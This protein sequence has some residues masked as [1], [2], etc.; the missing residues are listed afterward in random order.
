MNSLLKRAVVFSITTTFVFN[1]GLGQILSYADTSEIYK[2]A[3]D[4][5]SSF[6][7]KNIAQANYSVATT[8]EVSTNSDSSTFGDFTY[9]EENGSVTITEY[10]GSDASIVIPSKINNMNVTAIGPH[11]F[12][13]KGLK[14]VTIPNSVTSIGNYAFARCVLLEE[15]IIPNSVTSIGNAA[16][17]GCNHLKKVTIP[18]SVTSIGDS[19]FFNCQLL[20]T[21]VIPSSVTSIGDSAFSSI[22][23]DATI[24]GYPDSYAEEYATQYNIQ[25]KSIFL[26]FQ[27]SN[28][29]IDTNS[30]GDICLEFNSSN[31]NPE[32]INYEIRDENLLSIYKK[33]YKSETTD[34]YYDGCIVLSL[35]TGENPG[36]TTITATTSDGKTATCTIEVNKD[37]DPIP[38][39]PE[40]PEN[41]ED[42]DPIIILPGILG[43][44]FFNDDTN[45][46]DSN[47]V[48]APSGM[49]DSYAL[50]AKLLR[51]LAIRPCENQWDDENGTIAKYGREYGAKD[52]YKELV[53]TLSAKYNNKRKVYF[54]S[55]DW[56][57]S[58]SDSAKE[59]KNFIDG[60]NVDKVDLVCHSMG[61]L[62]ASSY[63]SQYKSDDKIDKVITCGTPYEGAP[64]IINKVQNWDILATELKVND[65]D[66]WMDCLSDGYLGVF[67]AF[68]K[69]IKS[70]IASTAE[71]APT[72][73]Y[74]SKTPMYKDKLLGDEYKLSTADYLDICQ[75]IYHD[76]SSS[77]NFQNS[78]RSDGYNTLLNYDKSYF[79]IGTG[80]KTI[81]SI[82]F[83]SYNNDISRL[84]YD[85]GDGTVPYLSGSIMEQIDELSR[86]RY[87]KPDLSHTGVIGHV[88]T[89]NGKKDTGEK[90]R[91]V[92]NWIIDILDKGESTQEIQSP[93]KIIKGNMVL[94]IACPVDVKVESN[95]ETLNSSP[96]QM[97][98]STSFGRL[99]IVGENDDIK[100]LCLDKSD[101]YNV[102]L[103]GT[104]EGTMDYTIRYF[105][106]ENVL[107]DE[108][109]I[110]DVPVTE[111]TIITTNP[112]ST[113]GIVLNVDF[114]GDKTVDKTYEAPKGETVDVENIVRFN[115][116]NG[117]KEITKVVDSEG[118][119]NYTPEAPTKDGY[120]FVGW[121]KDVNDTTTEY[122]SGAKYTEDVT[123]TAKWIYG[124]IS[125]AKVNNVSVN[126]ATEDSIELK[127]DEVDNASGYEVYKFDEETND[128]VNI[129]LVESNVLSYE[130]TNL[131]PDKEY[132]YKVRAYIEV[133][134]FNVYGDFSEELKAKTEPKKDELPV[135][136][137]GT[138]ISKSNVRSK[139]SIISKK[140][141]DLGKGTNVE[142][143]GKSNGWY[144]IK[145]NGSYGYVSALLV[146]IK[147]V[148]GSVIDKSDVRSKP[149]KSSK[150][151]GELAKGTNV[152]IVGKLN[153]WYKIKYN[154]SY[155][156]VSTKYVKTSSVLNHIII[157]N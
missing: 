117:T 154:G 60:L 29:S 2:N 111:D 18:N 75:K 155:G 24:Y 120:T 53:D 50:G 7:V 47:V 114:D 146:K 86:E 153:S 130:D 106:S 115:P 156:Y 87:I 107:E 14:K 97:C 43:S 150:K 128:F 40:D 138:T 59:L 49:M 5:I 34:G 16:F 48:W 73:K 54:F 45:F 110:K 125:I 64:V 72:A 74:V 68:D 100:M 61:G 56:R 80:Q 82:V 140:L 134:G 33:E 151:L 46:S 76:Y 35:K 98:T 84:I 135:I 116:D 22:K 78:I 13:E 147:L 79:V 108:T 124:N 8:N 90:T 109:T 118:K 157:W 51:G 3:K 144:K 99:D 102:T 148:F 105:N 25:F 91:E 122:K 104:D 113:E 93:D 88:D 39:V 9:T 127:W 141:G 65:W 12:Q 30:N 81:S 126:K 131:N 58:N 101:N 89:K 94:G 21:I 42:D 71:V 103:N 70:S 136:A 55:Y 137:L 28:Y 85:D 38:E 149:L 57:E 129:P 62:V 143:V 133:N 4:I 11:A 152:E 37:E 23:A 121:F 83:N 41:P 132:T 66:S 123:Y 52:T 44:R 145:Y 27:E 119:L 95:D 19:A 26:G 92:I 20:S 1:S 142:I 31:T 77:L 17:F 15:V 6:E 67:G 96:S 10:T 112:V 63:F 32:D 69:D 36:V 139:S